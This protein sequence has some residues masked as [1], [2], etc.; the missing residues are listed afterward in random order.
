MIGKG[1]D[2]KEKVIDSEKELKK[3]VEENGVKYELVRTEMKEENRQSG[4]GRKM[5]TAFEAYPSA[6][7]EEMVP[8]I[9]NVTVTDSETGEKMEVVAELTGL[10]ETGTAVSQTHMTVTYE[11]YD[12]AYYQ[13]HGH[14]IPKNE[15]QPPI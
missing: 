1:S 5:V 4:T 8:K 3:T 12:A 15:E 6:V 11:D 13:Y 9:K 14:L 10:T 7:T 2:K